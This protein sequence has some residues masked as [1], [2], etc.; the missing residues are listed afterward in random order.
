MT[1]PELAADAPVLDVPHPLEVGLVPVFGNEADP[2]VLDRADRGPG[3]RCDAHVPLV[4]QPGLDDGAAAI[5]P[6][7]RQPVRLDLFQEPRRLEVGDDAF[8]GLEAVEA[9]V[10]RRGFVADLR[11]RGQDI[12]EREPEPLPHLVIVEIV[13]GRQLDAAGA[14]GRVGELVGDERDLAARERQRQFL[15]GEPA[16]SL[17]AGMEGDGHV[18]EHRFGP[19]RRDRDMTL[20]VREGIADVPQAS[21]FFLRLHLEVGYGGLQHRVPVDQ[22]LAAVDQPLG[23]EAHEG[24]LDRLRHAGVHREAVA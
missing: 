19:R 23:M 17:V 20:A 3:E 2:A 13:R 16:V 21:R 7:D 5:A 22:A 14:K 15:S 10:G 1:P 12:D 11:V 18:A 9:A 8:A 6:R 24:L 4:G